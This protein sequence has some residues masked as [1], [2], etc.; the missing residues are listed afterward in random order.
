[1]KIAV[2]CWGSI[3]WD[4]G[5]L[6]T[7]GQW[8]KDGPPL[9]LEFCRI[10]SPRKPKERVTLVIN[11]ESAPTSTYW[12]YMEASDL[13]SARN[14]L[15]D[16]EGA[17][18]DDIHIFTRGQNPLSRVAQIIESWLELHPE[19]DVVIWTGVESNWFQVRGTK[20]SSEDFH[21]YLEGKKKSIQKIKEVFEK[22]PGDIQTK[23]SDIFKAWLI[24]TNP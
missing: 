5:S 12:N 16:R 18:T 22:T 23:G 8:K 6:K 13:K 4:Q 9:P 15:R 10:S 7:S 1:M 21:L 14:N 24:K 11:E 2:I 3:L 20:Y 19:V 17:V